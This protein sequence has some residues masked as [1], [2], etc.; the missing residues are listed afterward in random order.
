MAKQK[1][2]KKGIVRVIRTVVILILV[3]IVGLIGWNYF[4]PM[5]T[6][7]SITLYDSY[8]V[9][10]GDIQTT[11]SFSATL[12]VKKSETH[13]ASEMTK[14][15]EIYVKSGD[16]VSEGDSLVLLSNGELLTAGIDGVVNEMRFS[17]GDWVR[18][19]FTIV[20]VSDLVNLSVTMSVDEYDV[21]SLKIGQSCTVRVISLGIDFETTIAHIDRVSSSSGTLA[22]YT[23]TCDLAVPENVLPGMRATVIIP[24]QSVEGVNILPMDALAFDDDES[25]YV[26][27]KEGSNDYTKQYVETGLSDGMNVEIKSGVDTGD[28]VYAVGGTESASAAFSLEDIYIAIFGKKTVINETRGSMM[29]G[30]DGTGFTMPDGATMPDGSSMPEGFT[31]P[32]G[33]TMPDGSETTDATTTTDGSEATD[34]TTTTDGSTMP[35]GM[36]MPD[37]ASMPDGS[38]MPDGAS[39]PD[40]ATMPDGSAAATDGQSTDAA[41]G[42][43]VQDVQDLINLQD[44]QDASTV[45]DDQTTD[46]NA[47]P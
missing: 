39:M 28:T 8:T 16:S 36:T 6:A 24:D 14:I 45:Q 23:V 42:Q 21:K 9:E 44:A 12:A 10:Q 3:A 2:K 22:Y 5:L 30:S 13:S 37:G 38:T 19:N 1:P 11:L 15:K 20:Q 40:G 7:D 25:A 4:T 47:A 46:T 43:S 27:L 41:D 31:M 26:L 29:G 18:S 34:A 32:D 17:V 35:E 33:A